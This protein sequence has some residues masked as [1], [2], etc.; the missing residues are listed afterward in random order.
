MRLTAAKAIPVRVGVKPIR[1]LQRIMNDASM[2][3]HFAC[4][5][6]MRSGLSPIVSMVVRV[7]VSLLC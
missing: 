2:G 1:L 3:G 5:N 4:L 7:I 6:P